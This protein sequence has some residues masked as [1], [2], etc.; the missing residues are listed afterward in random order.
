[1]SIP[2]KSFEYLITNTKNVLSL[3]DIGEINSGYKCT[4]EQ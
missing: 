2:D 4:G 1:M 3:Y